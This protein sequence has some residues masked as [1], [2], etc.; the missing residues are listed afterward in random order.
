LRRLCDRRRIE[1]TLSALSN[2]RR[3]RPA[4]EDSI[5]MREKADPDT[6]RLWTEVDDRVLKVGLEGGRSI[7]EVATSL[8]RS[9]EEIEKRMR[10]MGLSVAT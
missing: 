5:V 7:R 6:E 2:I 4:N 9:V 10:D 8:R 3:G 1:P